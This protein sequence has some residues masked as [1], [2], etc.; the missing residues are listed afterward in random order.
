MGGVSDLAQKLITDPKS[1]WMTGAKYLGTAAKFAGPAFAIASI[2]LQKDVPSDQEVMKKYHEE[3]WFHTF[4][5]QLLS[6]HVTL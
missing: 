1:K 2:Y 6:N 4:S 3:V 5:T